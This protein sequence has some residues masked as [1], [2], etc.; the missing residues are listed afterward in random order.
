MASG[1][2]ASISVTGQGISIAPTATG[3]GA[4]ITLPGSSLTEGARIDM[5]VNASNEFVASGV[6]LQIFAQLLADPWDGEWDCWEANNKLVA[7]T[8]QTISCTIN[9]ATK[10]FNQT[11]NSVKI[12]I[13]PMKGM[14]AGTTAAGTLVVKSTKITLVG[15]TASS[16]S[17]STSSSSIA[18]SS[19][20]QA[21]SAPPLTGVSAIPVTPFIVVDQFGYLPTAQKIAVL[22]DPQ[23][24]YDATFSFN[25]STSISL[26]NT[27]TG[28]VIVSAAPV[29]WNS[30]NTDATSGDKVWWFDFSSVT[31]PGTYAV[32]DK[33][34]NLRSPS[35]K[36]A[37]DVYKPVLK[38]AF[39]TF[40]YQRAGFAKKQPF[41][42]AGWEDNASHLGACQDK[43]SRLFTDK[44]NAATEKD[45]SGGWFDAG[46]Y[47]KYTNFH[48]NY[49]ISL[50]N[51][52]I[53]NPAAWGDDY[54][55]PESGN[56]IPDILDE[57]KWGFDWLKRMQNANGSVLAIQGIASASPPSAATGCSYYGPASTSATL[58]S[59]AAFALGSKI[60]AAAGNS[61][62]ATYAA[63]LKT[64]A[65]N[66]WTWAQANPAVTVYNNDKALDPS[67]EGLAAG[68]Q[69]VDATTRAE[70]KVRAAIYLFAATNNS[71][72]HDV[73]K[74]SFT[75]GTGYY[76]SMWNE[77][78]V[79]LPWLYYAKL[80]TADATIASN[81]ISR[82]NSTMNGADHFAD[83][84]NKSDAYRAYLGTTNF[85]WG[86]NRSMSRQGN[87][88]TNLVTYSV[89]THGS[90]PASARN[91]ALG[92]L[93]YLH[94]VNPQATV[95]LSNMYSLGVHKSVNEFYH[96]WFADK[97]AKW[98]RVGSSTYGPAPGFLVGGPNPSYMWDEGKCGKL[99][100]S[101]EPLCGTY[102]LS[103][104]YGQPPM[105]SYLE[106]NTNWPINSWQVTEN[107]NDY[108][109]AYLRLLSKFVTNP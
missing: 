31:T 18:A 95:Y 40:F 81:M 55:I 65:E 3:Q 71:T 72:Y 32:V 76:I 85:G 92:Y 58:G 7:N 62:L 74:A 38:H 103:P 46:D 11:A 57:I 42:E 89:G 105:K 68:Q 36:I 96:T 88:F 43:N 21:S 28:N 98:D 101:S 61:E 25:P 22:R 66:A 78:Y 63:D 83:V 64:R 53:E 59:A 50:L 1:T 80:P 27:E 102:I 12:A 10:M 56:G 17:S 106:F 87:T 109:V 49:L 2:G 108:Q 8:D 14:G 60:F 94:G 86:S 9:T 5:V 20:S 15:S 6:S 48:A 30:G 75:T 67:L 34:Q 54:N 107:H 51:A 52:Y 73:V 82:Y 23:T 84:T 99:T 4:A 44:N 37:A 70:R 39:R 45:L 26:V 104:P 69:E 33:N 100:T 35:F 47:N 19:S 77:E 97:S 79:M 90:N 91:A 93:N 29:L 13:Q 41:A 24:G 16:S